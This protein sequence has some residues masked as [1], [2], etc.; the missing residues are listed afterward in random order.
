LLLSLAFIFTS[1]VTHFS[2]SVIEND[3]FRLLYRN[4]Y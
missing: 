3:T 2:F 4:E 1:F